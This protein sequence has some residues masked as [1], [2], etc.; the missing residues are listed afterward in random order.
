MH[1]ATTHTLGLAHTQSKHTY[2]PVMQNTTETTKITL[3]TLHMILRTTSKA[4]K[5]ML[6]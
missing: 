6:F 2:E 1:A 4:V 3:K 5:A